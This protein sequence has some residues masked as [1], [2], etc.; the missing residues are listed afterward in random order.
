MT[1]GWRIFL[2]NLEL[3]LEHFSGQAAT[4]M[5]PTAT[6]AG[7]QVEAWNRLSGA[8]GIDAAPAVGDRVEVSGEG[9][10]ALAGTVADVAG[11]RMALV[12]EEPTPGTAFL[13]VEGSGDEVEVSI[14]SYLYG[15]DALEIVER[16]D[17]LWR[18][19][20]TTHG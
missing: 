3:H 7:P 8:L 9:V 15:P 1:E 11:W 2:F 19:W 14:W 13:A 4:A 12:L 18:E 16:D 17:P 6:W 10:P 5:L 20:L